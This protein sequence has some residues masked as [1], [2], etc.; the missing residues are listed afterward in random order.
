MKKSLLIGIAIVSCMTATAQWT[1]DP[2]VN[3]K[4][5]PEDQGVYAE[6]FAV[7]K[8]GLIYYNYNGPTGGT[9][10]TFLQILDKH[11]N[12][13]LK[14]PGLTISTERARGWVAVNQMLMVDKEGN[15]I[16]SV[17]D[18][19]YAPIGSQN[20]SYTV[21]KVSPTGEMLWGEDGIG[22]E[23]GE[24]SDSEANMNIIQ[25]ED[26]SYVFA[27]TR[28]VAN[29][30]PFSIHMQRLSSTGEFLWDEPVT[31]S[32]ENITY[33]YSW[34]VNAG[35]N[36]F[37]LVYSKG[38]NQDLMAQKYDFDGT[39]VWP[40]ELT[41]YRGGFG[42]IPIWTFID[43]I[44][45]EKGGAF[46]GWYDDRYY[47][48]FSKS[49]V[50]HITTDGELGFIDGIEGTALSN[51]EYLMGFGPKMIYD[52]KNDC[53]FTVHR[54]TDKN[55]SWNHLVVQKVSMEGELL[56]GAEGKELTT[57]TNQGSV[58]YS[59]IQTTGDGDVVVFYMY[60]DGLAGNSNVL[61]YA[62]RLDGESEDATRVWGEEPVL[63][64]TIES[65][66]SSLESSPL[67]DN[68]YYVTM[69][70]DHILINTE[71]GGSR[72][73]DRT[74]MQCIKLDG[75][76]L[77]VPSSIDNI[78]ENQGLALTASATK[79]NVA[80]CINSEKSRLAEL[81]IYSISGQKVAVVFN[82]ELDNGTKDVTWRTSNI[83]A[84]VYI[85]TLTTS[86]GSKSI[87]IIVK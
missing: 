25:L 80:F 13:T 23:K 59:T 74:F 38:T 44:P 7:N 48:G 53:L 31:I 29:G 43:V 27:W 39:P 14:D 3:T 10:A 18:C 71:D 26:G 75:T 66:K 32:D 4:V 62:V 79:D 33:I 73:E 70:N 60:L 12:K 19:R 61:T 78:Y 5:S 50:S 37:V 45:D 16:I 36:Q 72:S 49:Y 69:W 1:N 54:E 20:L 24:I 34:I 77:S 58:S 84:G 46:V 22:L 40:E 52:S 6:E 2:A 57:L 67:V 42:S 15:A 28:S 83:N 8:D 51:P 81:N 55:Q 17:S 21:Y 86:E 30:A 68:S 41:V 35:D 9:T 56:W 76:L 64:S 82:G 65:N 63:L 87:R 11:G 47:S 85:A